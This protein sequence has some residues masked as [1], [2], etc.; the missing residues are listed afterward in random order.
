LDLLDQMEQAA[1]ATAS[2]A[3]HLDWRLSEFA[4]QVDALAREMDFGFLY[5]PQRK[6]FSIGFNL[7]DGHLDRSHYDM[8]A[9]EARLASYLAIA[10]GDVEYQHWFRMSR[11]LTET[12]GQVGL[13]SWGGTMF[14]Y[15]MPQL[16]Q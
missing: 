5:N 12:A 6:L 10:K 14:E 2:A 1:A 13:L 11:V 16:F 8:L 4:H 9:S 3:A 15:L 7:E